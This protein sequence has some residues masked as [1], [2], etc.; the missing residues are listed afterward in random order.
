MTRLARAAK[1]DARGASG[2]DGGVMA[3][4]RLFF[5]NEVSAMAPKPWA[6]LPR[7]WRRVMPCSC[8][9]FRF[10][11]S[12]FP[13]SFHQHLVQVE[14]DIANHRPGGQLGHITI[15]WRCTQRLGGNIAC[16]F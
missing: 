10:M 16:F 6:D 8:S 5:S 11:S 2:S 15:L 9:R 12:C 13:S 7:K 4:E 1:C 14:Q 3:A